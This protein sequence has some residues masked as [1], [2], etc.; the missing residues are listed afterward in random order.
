MTDSNDSTVS[1]TSTAS[2][3]ARVAAFR[4]L[5]AELKRREALPP[6]LLARAPSG[7]ALLPPDALLL[8]RLDGHCF[9]TYVTGLAGP[10]RCAA[11]A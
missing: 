5:A 6:A 4:A 11:L 10:V 8:A 9:S 7:D 2:N 1:V 3:G